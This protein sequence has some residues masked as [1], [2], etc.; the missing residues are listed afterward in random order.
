MRDGAV[1]PVDAAALRAV[2][3][4]ALRLLSIAMP[5]IGLAMV[6]AAVAR[7]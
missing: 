6:L 4:S 7:S 2:P 1:E 3:E 5:L